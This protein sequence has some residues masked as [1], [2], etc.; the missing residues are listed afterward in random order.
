M[1]RSENGAVRLKGSLTL[2]KMRRLVAVADVDGSEPRLPGHRDDP[3]MADG[4]RDR[5]EE[6]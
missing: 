6:L 4:A 1:F 5:V 2:K 3:Y